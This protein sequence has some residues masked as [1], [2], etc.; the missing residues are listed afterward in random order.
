[1]S[2]NTENKIDVFSQYGFFAVDASNHMLDLIK[3]IEQAKGR[4]P[5]LFVIQNDLHLYRKFFKDISLG[6]VEVYK[7]EELNTPT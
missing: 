5:G 7:K 2:K 1:M 3:Y 6:K 4:T